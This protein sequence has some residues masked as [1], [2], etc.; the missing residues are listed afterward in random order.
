M[1]PHFLVNDKKD[2]VGVAVVDIQKGEKL[3]GACLEDGTR[4]AA[5]ARDSIPLGHKIALKDFEKGQDV[6]KYGVPVGITTQ[7]IVSGQHV[8]VHNVKSK[9]W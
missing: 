3:S 8:H 9:R 7:S 2:N 6:I 1:K 5:E 4:I